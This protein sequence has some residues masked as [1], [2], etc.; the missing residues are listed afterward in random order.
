MDPFSSVPLLAIGELVN[1]TSMFYNET[2][3]MYT[4]RAIPVLGNCSNCPETS[5]TKS[6]ILQSK[7]VY[8]YNTIH[9]SIYTNDTNHNN[10]KGNHDNNH[11]NDNNT[12]HTYYYYYYY[13]YYHYY[14]FIIIIIIIIINPFAGDPRPSQS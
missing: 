1:D 6:E 11:D 9:I 10:N 4:F 8:I 14:L 2:L 12:N 13:Y 3:Y 5:L 7:Y